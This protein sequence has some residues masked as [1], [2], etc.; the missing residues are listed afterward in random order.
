[1]SE[2]D[3]AEDVAR[4]RLADLIRETPG[5]SCAALSALIGRNHAY[6]QQYLRRGRPRSLAPRDVRTIAAWLGVPEHEIAGSGEARE[7]TGFGE[8]VGAPVFVAEL[9]AGAAARTGA[10]PFRPGRLAELMAGDPERLA[11]LTVEDD[12]MHPTLAR[13]DEVLIDLARRTPA[14][15]ALFAVRLDGCASIRRLAVNPVTGRIAI[16]TDNPLYAD[17]PDCDP[18][19]LDILG[20]AL[21]AG[22]RL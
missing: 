8:S 9:R 7:R 19:D 11:M 1:M 3:W 13:G 12:A 22:K 5:A 18:A 20:R 4:Q 21:W 14:R 16:R 10:T 6:I 15:E 2:D 17:W